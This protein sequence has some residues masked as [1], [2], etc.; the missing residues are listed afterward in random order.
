MSLTT[1]DDFPPLL[2]NGKYTSTILMREVFN[3]LRRI[4]KEGPVYE[5]GKT[6]QIMMRYVVFSKDYL[7]LSLKDAKER[8]FEYLEKAQRFVQE[9]EAID[10]DKPNYRLLLAA[11][12]TVRPYRILAESFG[13]GGLYKW[14]RW[15]YYHIL[16]PKLENV[17]TSL[18]VF[19]GILTVTENTTKGEFLAQIEIF[20]RM[21]PEIISTFQNPALFDAGLAGMLQI[22]SKSFVSYIDD[23]GNP[24]RNS[25]YI[26]A[27]EEGNEKRRNKLILKKMQRDLN[28][29]LLDEDMKQFRSQ[30]DVKSSSELQKRL[31]EKYKEIITD[32]G[33][34]L[35]QTKK[36]EKF[37][38]S[39]I[40]E[41]IS[42]VSGKITNVISGA[43]GKVS[44]W[45]G[46]PKVP[47]VTAHIPTAIGTFEMVEYK[48]LPDGFMR[49]VMEHV[50]SEYDITSL[51][52]LKR[53]L[54]KLNS[55]K[56]GSELREQ[57]IGVIDAVKNALGSIQGTY[58]PVLA[59][60]IAEVLDSKNA[61]LN[62][63]I[64]DDVM[65]SYLGPFTVSDQ[66]MTNHALTMMKWHENMSY[67]LD[68]KDAL[69]ERTL[70]LL[71]LADYI[72]FDYALYVIYSICVIYVAYF[73]LAYS[74][75]KTGRIRLSLHKRLET[76]YR[77]TYDFSSYNKKRSKYQI[78][79]SSRSRIPQVTNSTRK[80]T[81]RKL[82]L[83]RKK[84]SVV[85]R[86]RMS[87]K[88]KVNGKKVSAVVGRKRMSRTLN[89][90][91]KVNRK[92]VSV[93]GRRRPTSNR[94]SQKK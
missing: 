2:M 82:N 45:I 1:Q 11:K 3:H 72:T 33:R 51:D 60:K 87:R 75:T 14:F 47:N 91:V 88:L 23:E 42:D 19:R 25:Q 6:Y 21:G 89:D 90:G 64:L 20:L 61:I 17:Q 36:M 16:V 18:K 59:F 79:S 22:L 53:S 77:S 34:S 92:K 27:L 68:A 71:S 57:Y 62:A 44:D 65:R 4:E 83:I 84:V 37:K 28:K 80:R 55:S 70:W 31:V 38:Q 52:D 93:V 81:S 9:L 30:L 50:N 29:Q 73:L 13:G 54:D 67:L 86:K 39:E 7:T 43:V 85:G 15:Y 56:Y 10:E 78:R 40:S 63:D 35:I 41:T 5:N 66:D 8:E 26:T 74:G 32:K 94:Y 12:K 24:I 49:E 46:G 69:N 76:D 48:E 58:I